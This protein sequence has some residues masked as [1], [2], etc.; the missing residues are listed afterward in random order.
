MI[1]RTFLLTHPPHDSRS[2]AGGASYNDD[3]RGKYHVAC[4]PR[5]IRQCGYAKSSSML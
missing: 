2:G 3:E 4:P 1:V 5:S